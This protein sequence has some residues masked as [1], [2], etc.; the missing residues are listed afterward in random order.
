M[1]K[2]E[3]QYSIVEA[4]YLVNDSV[5]YIY[6]GPNRAFILPVSAFTDATQLEE[7]KAFISEKTVPLCP[8]FLT[9]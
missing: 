4:V 9:E 8:L 1:E 3:Y 5:L 2:I 7:F 6:T